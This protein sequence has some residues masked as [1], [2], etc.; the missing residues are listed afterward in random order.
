MDRPDRARCM[1]THCGRRRGRPQP[2]VGCGTMMNRAAPFVSSPHG[3]DGLHVTLDP[4]HGRRGRDPECMFTKVIAG[5]DGTPESQAAAEWAADQ[6]K[7]V[8]LTLVHAI[9]GKPTGSE[10]LQATGERSA[11][12]I[13]LMD[14]ADHL[15]ATRPDLRVET[16]V[17]HGSAID[18][19]GERL[20]P[21][22]LI[23]VGG[24]NH[25]RTTRWTL[26]SRLAGRR[27]G[28]LVAVIPEIPATE[29]RDAV[30]AGVDGSHASMAAVEIAAAEADRLGAPLEIVHVWQVPA[31]W[32]TALREYGSD[33]D[34]LEEIHREL[35]D[36]AV[37]YAWEL[38]AKPT[39]RLETGAPVDVLRRIATTAALLVVASHGSG[40]F[41][42]FLLGSVSHDLL[43]EPPAP[44]LI[45]APKV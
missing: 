22:A 24:P 39:G 42:R 9:G 20:A 44:M 21:D 19:L 25:R 3:G 32:D 38:G 23:V 10:Y 7:E 28:G 16:E 5:W 11:E 27:G 30:V 37:G 12:R 33:V 13:K 18:V 2:A 4:S 36:E 34:T 14:V 1:D 29:R 15:R 41:A 43:V 40:G 8:P 31:E 26:G 6:C 17:V 35:L 45:V